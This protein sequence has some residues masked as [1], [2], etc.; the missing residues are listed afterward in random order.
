MCHRRSRVWGTPV[1]RLLDFLRP[2]ERST[3]T[4]GPSDIGT[5]FFIKETLFVAEPPSYIQKVN[6]QANLP[7]DSDRSPTKK[8][9]SRV[10]R[11]CSA[12]PDAPFGSLAPW[13][14]SG[15]PCA[16]RLSILQMSLRFQVAPASNFGRSD[17]RVCQTGPNAR[18]WLSKDLFA[19]I[20]RRLSR[21]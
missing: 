19:N 15:L 13:V 21:A 12:S 14:L 11:C 6:L 16:S 2:R 18:P 3:A 10:H 20:T 9:S 17:Y 1:S 8:S 4:L 7:P 5:F